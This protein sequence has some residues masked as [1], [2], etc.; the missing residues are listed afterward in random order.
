MKKVI[1]ILAIALFA[2]CT[3]E[4]TPTPTGTNNNIDCLCGVVVE[5][6][7]FN[8]VNPNGG[9]TQFSALTMKRNCTGV[10]NQIQRNGVIRVGTQICNY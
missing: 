4:A 1:L 6:S 2:S 8:V 7:S 3:P 5:S 9:I 10:F